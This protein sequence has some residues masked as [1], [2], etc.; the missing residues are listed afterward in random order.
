[1]AILWYPALIRLGD[2]ELYNINHHRGLWSS[3]CWDGG[4]DGCCRDSGGS[5]GGRIPNHTLL[6]TLVLTMNG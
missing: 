6:S 3:Y 5:G 2:P 4:S 1:M